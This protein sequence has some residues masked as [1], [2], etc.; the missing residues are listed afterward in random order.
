VAIGQPRAAKLNSRVGRRIALDPVFEREV[1]VA[2]RAVPPEKIVAVEFV[3]GRDLRG[4]EVCF[5]P[6]PVGSAAPP[7]Q[8]PRSVLDSAE[9]VT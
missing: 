4:D 1:E 9:P 7:R 5:D 8:R 6:P 3:A 2:D